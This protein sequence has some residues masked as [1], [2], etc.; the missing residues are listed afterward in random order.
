MQLPDALPG[1]IDGLRSS[2][3]ASRNNKFK[4]FTAATQRRLIL[5]HAEAISKGP[6][7]ARAPF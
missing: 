4:A 1:G 7:I 2:V 5:T 3:G 6:P